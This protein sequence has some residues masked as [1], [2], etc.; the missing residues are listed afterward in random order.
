MR[1]PNSLPVTALLTA[2]VALGPLSTDLYLPSLPSLARYFAVGVDDIQLTLSVF[3]VGLATAQLVYGP[4]SD[5]F[6][7]RPVLLVGLAIYVVASVVCML[8]PSVPVLVVARFVQA[9]GACVGPVLGRAVVRDVYGREGAARV[10]AYM[11]AAMALAPAIGPILGGFLEEW[12]GWR[13]NFLALV[14]YGSGGLVLAW[15]LLPE[16]N[17]APDL[18]AAQPIRILLGYRGFLNHRA[19]LGYVLCCAFAYSGIF[20]FISGSSYVLQEVVGLGPI[21]FGLCF[22]GVVIGYIIG[23]VVA[24]RLSRRLG[25]DRLIAVGAGIGVAGGTLLLALALAS[26]PHRRSHAGVHDRRRPGAAELDRRRHR[27]VPARRRRRLG[28]ARLHSDDRGRR[29]RHRRRRPLRRQRD[30]HDGHH[31]DRGGRRA[32]GVQVVGARGEEVVGATGRSPA[33]LSRRPAGDLPVVPTYSSPYASRSSPAS[34]GAMPRGRR[35][36][37]CRRPRGSDIRRRCPGST[38]PPAPCGQAAAAAGP[39]RHRGRSP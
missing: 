6:G 4:L 13:I 39:A 23:T 3:L 35:I 25:I 30:T 12:F 24:G 8:A 16:T 15:R 33:C 22:A 10:L 1:A 37:C 19:Y 18:Q 32:A 31:C 27:T 21:G 26:A 17:K 20:A 11:S 28:P 34:P 29:H 2:L 14:L 36:A 5:R 9:V 38:P 7:R